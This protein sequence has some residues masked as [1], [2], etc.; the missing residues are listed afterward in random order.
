MQGPLMNARKLL[1]T[2][3]GTG[4]LVFGVAVPASASP[5]GVTGATIAVTGG[6]LAISV[7]TGTVALGTRADTVGGGTISGQLGEVQVTDARGAPAG[8]GWV[9]SVISTA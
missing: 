5:P 7:P 3:A 2:A 4:L 8:S 1:M 6:A 9:A